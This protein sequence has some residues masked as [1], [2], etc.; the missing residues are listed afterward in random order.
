MRIVS[1]ITPMT[2]ETLRPMGMVRATHTAR[3][4]EYHI[5]KPATIT[6]TALDLPPA[7]VADQR[8]PLTRRVRAS[9][10]HTAH[11][12]CSIASYRWL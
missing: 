2:L 8:S 5:H 7:V 12:T 4:L 11:A 3:G 1:S 9:S 6:A 10:I